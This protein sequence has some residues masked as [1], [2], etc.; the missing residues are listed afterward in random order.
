MTLFLNDVCTVLNITYKSFKNENTF[1]KFMEKPH[2][3]SWL[4]KSYKCIS[5]I[6][7]W[8]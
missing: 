7:N 2:F 1:A 4:C 8:K 3:F 6:R 5:K